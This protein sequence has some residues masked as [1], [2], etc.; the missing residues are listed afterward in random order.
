MTLIRLSLFVATL[1]VAGGGICA[2]Q[3][4]VPL[5]Q[6]KPAAIAPAPKAKATEHKGAEHKGDRA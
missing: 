2:A 5:P 4:Q 1:L 6:A 3:T